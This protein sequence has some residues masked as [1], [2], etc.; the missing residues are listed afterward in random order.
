MLTALEH[1]TTWLRF[2]SIRDERGA[3][4]VEYSLLLVLL[5]L[6]C[7]AAVGVLGH[8]AQSTFDSTGSATHVG[9]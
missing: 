1:L 2:R 9:G 3:S 8:T 6:I 4:M 5:A 7:I